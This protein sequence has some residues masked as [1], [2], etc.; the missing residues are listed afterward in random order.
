[1]NWSFESMHSFIG[2]GMWI[3]WLILL[4]IIVLLV[5]VMGVPS[6]NS[7]SAMELLKKRYANGEIGKEEFEEIKKTLQS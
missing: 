4:V 6:K 7:E 5:K 3:F 1:M 2:G